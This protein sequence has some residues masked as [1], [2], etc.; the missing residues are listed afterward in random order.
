MSVTCM[1][2]L[3]LMELARMLTRDHNL[4]RDLLLEAKKMYYH[5]S[6]NMISIYVTD[7]DP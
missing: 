5:A 4:L 3:V 1:A 2:T 6:K 7:P